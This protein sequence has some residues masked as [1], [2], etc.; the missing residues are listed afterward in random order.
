MK[1]TQSWK[2]AYVLFRAGNIFAGQT[3]FLRVQDITK[4]YHVIFDVICKKNFA[5][6]VQNKKYVLHSIKS[7]TLLGSK[8]LPYR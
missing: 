6:S 7:F 1:T 3:N 4:V 8:V 5:Y 2:T